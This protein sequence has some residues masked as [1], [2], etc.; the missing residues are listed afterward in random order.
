VTHRLVRDGDAGG[1]AG[2]SQAIAL[3]HR[4]AEADFK[5]LLHVVGQGGATCHDEAHLPAQA[6]LNLAEDQTVKEW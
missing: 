6:G 2:L 5:E 4:A 3:H 1:S